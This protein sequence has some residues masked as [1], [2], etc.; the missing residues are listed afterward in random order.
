MSADLTE[1]DVPI[2]KLSEIKP[3]QNRFKT[4]FKV[5]E[6]SEEKSVTNKNSEEEHLMSDITIADDTASIIL[7]AWDDD[8]NFLE[9]DKY[10]S[11]TNGYVNIYKSSMRLARGRYGVFE[12][13]E[14]EF[15]VNT[16]NNR[17]NEVHE[18]RKRRNYRRPRR[19]YDNEE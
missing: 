11:L 10:F 17:S 3:F 2:V 1:Q 12:A 7:T 13:S 14:E 9:I 16:E 8:I 19:N 15:E 4:I 6:K 18:N 5:L